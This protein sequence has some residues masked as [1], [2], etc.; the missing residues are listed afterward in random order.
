MDWYDYGARFYDPQI[1]RFT[2]QDAFAEKYHS[3]TPYQYGANNP[4][5]FID[6]NGDSINFSGVLRDGGIKALVNILSDLSEQTGLNSIGVNKNGNL[7]YGTDDKGNAQVMTDDEGNQMGSATARSFLTNAASDTK[8]FINVSL[9]D[10]AGSATQDN[11]IG[12]DPT[13]IQNFIDG[14]SGNLN[15]KTLGF[16][17]TFLHELHHTDFAGSLPDTDVEGAKGPTVDQ[18][19]KIRGELDTNPI[20][21]YLGNG[22]IY[23]IRSQYHG[24]SNGAVNGR[25]GYEHVYIPF[26]GKRNQINYQGKIKIK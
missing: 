10:G 7:T 1:G 9:R 18:M 21:K 6:V 26:N 11:N 23:G 22:T 3:M 12:L 17:M 16:G 14:T 20:N 24:V 25:P 19:N 2:T 4:V 15:S 5:L 13:Q 8:S